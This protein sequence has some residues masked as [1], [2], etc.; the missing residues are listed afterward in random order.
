MSP[1]KRGDFY[2]LYIPRRS[3]GVVQRA[4]GTKDPKLAKAMGRMIDTLADQRRWDVLEALDAKTF[5]VGQ[6]YDAFVMN[7]LDALLRDSTAPYMATLIDG[8]VATLS[9]QPQ[10]KR[11]YESKVR[12][13]IPGD[14]LASHFTPGW[15]A[16]A[17][18]SL[19]HSS[20][21]KRGYLQVLSLFADYAVAHRIIANNPV[22][23][24]GLVR[25]PRA[26]APRKR[27]VTA[28]MDL[29]LVQATTD[30]VIRA[31]FA[32]VHATGAERNAA[33]AMR[34][35]DVDLENWTV[36]I[37]GTKTKTRDRY[38][39]PVEAWAH[40]FIR[41]LCVGLVPDALLFPGLGEMA[42]ATAH[43]DAANAVHLEG[44]QLRDGRHSYAVRALLGGAPLWQV[45]KWLGPRERGD[46]RGSLH[47]VR[48]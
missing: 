20:G 15:C 35:R 34:R 31:Y 3:G 44:Y 4:C 2:S 18:A 48:H 16:D 37:P 9:L 45:S 38:G 22:R 8:W 12:A 41:H 1:F 24:K 10:T 27:W 39:V 46:Y 6:C 14:L 23:E 32:L 28:D 40:P 29:R 17:I 5:T 42:V 21:T 33:F 25:R 30:P 11:A 19:P 13:M 43:L 7:G 47:T 36:H 26:N